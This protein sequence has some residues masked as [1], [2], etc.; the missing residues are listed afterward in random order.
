MSQSVRVTAI[1]PYD[2]MVVLRLCRGWVC[3]GCCTPFNNVECEN[4]GFCVAIETETDLGLDERTLV[5]RPPIYC[6]RL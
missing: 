2:E 3:P 4:C 5:G 6:E 1:T